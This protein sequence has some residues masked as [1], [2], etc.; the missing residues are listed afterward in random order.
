MESRRA[1]SCPLG[2][3]LSFPFPL[4]LKHENEMSSRADPINR[5]RLLVVGGGGAVGFAAIQ[6]AVAAGCH[7]TST[8]GS[9]SINRLSAAGAKQA[10]DSTVEV[11]NC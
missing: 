4:L 3:T 11:M 1:L 6:L 7:V 8:C 5:L 2:K 10:V 9:Q